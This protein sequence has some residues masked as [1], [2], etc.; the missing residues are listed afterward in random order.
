MGDLLSFL[1][2]EAEEIEDGLW[3]ACTVRA[4]RVRVRVRLRVRSTIRGGRVEHG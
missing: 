4:H 2:R 1:H 3:S